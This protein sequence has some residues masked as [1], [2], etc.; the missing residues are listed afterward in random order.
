MH[1]HLLI[2][3]ATLAALLF[4][5][6]LA[7]KECLSTADACDQGEAFQA[8][9]VIAEREGPRVCRLFGATYTGSA[10]DSDN[11]HSYRGRFNCSDGSVANGGTTYWTT[12]CSARPPLIGA[13][14]SDGSG[15]SCDDGCFYNFT[16]GG[17]KGNGMYPSGATCSVGDAPPSKPGDDGGGDGD[18][19]SD[20]GGDGGS[21][22]GGDGGSD[23][24]SH[25]GGDGGSHGGGDGGGDGHGDGDGDGHTPGDGD[26]KTPGDGEG[27]E[28]APMSELYKKSDKTAESVLSKFNTHV[29][30]APMVAGITNFMKVP[31]G[32]S[33]P[34]FSLA[35]SKFWDAMTINFHCGGDF[36]A[37]LRAAGWVIFAIAAYAALRIAVT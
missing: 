18:G 29:R 7:A 35:G 12:Q 30:A 33:C 10:V 34:V 19:G 2:I 22:G 9:H 31:S 8:A 16:I 32:G 27:G 4:A 5:E 36:L 15:A 3:F 17:E 23:G 6:P 28:G 14:S 26:G 24:G 11:P 1:R 25:G 37:F 21:D 13:S 20:G